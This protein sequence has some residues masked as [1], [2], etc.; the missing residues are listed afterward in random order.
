MDEPNLYK[1]QS[2]VEHLGRQVA[3]IDSKIVAMEEKTEAHRE[4]QIEVLTKLTAVTERLAANNDTNVRRDK[5][6]ER[7]NKDLKSLHADVD[8]LKTT[9][10]RITTIASATAGAGGIGVAEIV[11][12]IFG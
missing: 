11:K 5:E 9:S 4:R 10:V 1:I 3:S 7:L 6:F 12:L 8:E 2:D